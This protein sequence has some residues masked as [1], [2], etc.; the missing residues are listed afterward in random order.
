LLKYAG[1]SRS[2]P[3]GGERLTFSQA[4]Q[5]GESPSTGQSEPGHRGNAPASGLGASTARAKSCPPGCL[6]RASTMK[7]ELVHCAPQA[8]AAT[9]L[10]DVEL[11][12]LSRHGSQACQYQD[13]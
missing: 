12:T 1:I 9:L 4:L 13:M 8:L 10:P 7:A 2:P 5:A 3:R 11:M 6:S